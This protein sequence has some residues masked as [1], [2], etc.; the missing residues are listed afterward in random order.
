MSRP[1]KLPIIEALLWKL[2]IGSLYSKDKF[3]KAD[4]LFSISQRLKAAINRNI[5]KIFWA[6]PSSSTSLRDRR[7]GG[8]TIRGSPPAGGS[9]PGAGK[10]GTRDLR[11]TG[12]VPHFGLPKADL[13]IT[14]SRCF[15]FLY[16]LGK[17]DRTNDSSVRLRRPPTHRYRGV[18][19]ALKSITPNTK[20]RLLFFKGK[21]DIQ[22]L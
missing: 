16:R 8:A 22:H 12:G 13:F 6:I 20:D 14:H 10:S 18:H 21:H 2:W 11:S 1:N 7:D 17:E 4:K 15:H 9:A 5:F 19:C 3:I